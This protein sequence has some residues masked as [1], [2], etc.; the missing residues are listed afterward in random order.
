VWIV[1]VGFKPVR[2]LRLELQLL[3]INL[4]ADAEDVVAQGFIRRRSY[5]EV[6]AKAVAEVEAFEDLHDS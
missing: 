1:L 6:L 5:L 2:P 3:A 4:V